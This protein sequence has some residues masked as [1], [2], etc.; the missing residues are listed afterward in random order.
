M[1]V[2][3]VYHDSISNGEGWRSVLFVSGCPH[4]CKGC[5]NPNT[6]NREYG[7][8]YNE[9][10][11]FE[12][13][14]ENE[15]LDG[16]TISGGEPFLYTETLLPLVKKIKEKKLN[17]WVYT[18]YVWD[19]L[20][21]RAENDLCTHLFLETIDVIVDGRFEIEKKAPS[22]KFRGSC[23][24][25]IIDVKASIKEGVLIELED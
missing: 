7:S 15:L 3:G 4:R 11:V 10:E 19:E 25:R 12:Q 22:L 18:G 20:L 2:A 14:T 13:L 24:Q 6:W 9:E 8:P 16:V 1:N 17:I 21:R 23:N 5:H